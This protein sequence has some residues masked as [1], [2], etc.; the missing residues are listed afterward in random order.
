MCD[1]E[2][3]KVVD[4]TMIRKD[5]ISEIVTCAVRHHKN[6][7]EYDNH[8]I[9]IPFLIQERRLLV[10]KITGLLNLLEFLSFAI[11]RQLRLSCSLDLCCVTL[12]AGRSVMLCTGM[13]G[14]LLSIV[15]REILM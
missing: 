1:Y 5:S 8:Y 12:Y 15:V 7:I 4:V 14:V 13:V 10:N 11:Y 2:M 3:I 6:L 9:H